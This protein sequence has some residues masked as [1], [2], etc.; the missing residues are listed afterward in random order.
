MYVRTLSKLA[1]L[2]VKRYLSFPP[3]LLP[4]FLLSFLLLYLRARFVH[5]SGHSAA[6]A[7]ATGRR[8]R[9]ADLKVSR[10]A[11]AFESLFKSREDL[12]RLPDAISLESHYR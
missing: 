12:T 5:Y 9:I 4:S 6:A 1:T 8:Q 11:P 10:S 7:T 2:S 3:E